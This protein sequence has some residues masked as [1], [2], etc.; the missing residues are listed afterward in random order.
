MRRRVLTVAA[1]VV[2]SLAVALPA[3]SGDGGPPQGAVQGWDGLAHGAVRYVAVSIGNWTSVQVIRRNGGR[4]VQFMSI[5]GRWGIPLVAVDSPGD[6]LLRDERTLVLAQVSYGPTLR[7]Q[8]SFALVDM[9]RMRVLRKIHVDGHMTFDAVSPDG[10]YLYLTEFVSP[11]DFTA[12]RVR[13]FDVKANRLLPKIVSDRSTWETTMQGWPVSRVNRDGWA[14]TLYA[15]GGRPFIHALDTRHVAA[16]CINLPWDSEPRY[17]Y[18]YRVRFDRDG[19]LVVRGRHG[20]VL[21][22]VDRG[23]LRILSSVRNP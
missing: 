18:S 21:V 8:S 20:R 2:C 12:Y 22:T 14:F 23:S 6:A 4:L 16:V 19:H 17:I 1:G 5:K 3:A 9:K 7:K 13:A 15:T 10:R 11:Q